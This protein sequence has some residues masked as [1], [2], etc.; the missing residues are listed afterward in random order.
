MAGREEYFENIPDDIPGDW[1]WM[2]RGIWNAFS[3]EADETG[4]LRSDEYVQD[5]YHTAMH[6][7]NVTVEEREAAY[8]E[9]IDYLWD[10]YDIDFADEY[11]W[12]DFRAW[13]ESA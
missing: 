7:D 12:E 1:E 9:M 6:D 2:E 11:D 5:L 10:E 3:S 13:Y 8:Q 4:R